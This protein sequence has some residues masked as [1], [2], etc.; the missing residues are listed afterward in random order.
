M[1]FQNFG[2]TTFWYESFQTSLHQWPLPVLKWR[3]KGNHP[4]LATIY[5]YDFTSSIF[6]LFFVI[7]FIIIGGSYSIRKII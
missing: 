1:F 6:L 4:F 7:D 2:L 3:K 5:T